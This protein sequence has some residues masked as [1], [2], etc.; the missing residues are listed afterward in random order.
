[1]LAHV[2]LQQIKGGSQRKKEEYEAILKVLVENGFVYRRGDAQCA[3]SLYPE[4]LKAV[5]ELLLASGAA[6]VEGK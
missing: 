1:M 6:I 4:A 2:A 5:E 3:M